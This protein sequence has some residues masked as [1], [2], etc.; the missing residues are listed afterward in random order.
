[1]SENERRIIPIYSSRGEVDAFL[2]FPYLFNRGGEWI[3]VVT[4]QREVYSVLGSY[5]GFLTNDPRIVRKRSDDTVR[6]RLKVHPFEGR[7]NIPATI[8]LAP[9]MG[10]LSQSLVD[11]LCDEPERLHTVDTGEYRDDLD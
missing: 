7:M 2:A 10:D 8:P 5:V 1:M 4:A 3:G 11:V 9:L 6:P